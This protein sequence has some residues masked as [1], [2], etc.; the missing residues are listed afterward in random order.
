[1][2]VSAIAWC[3]RRLRRATS[4]EIV[5][6]VTADLPVE[7]LL[8]ATALLA[9][10]L[11]GSIPLAW[12]VVRGAR[13]AA[14]GAL[15]HGTEQDGD[16]GLA[17]DAIAAWGIAGPGWGMLAVVGDLAKGVVPVAVG[18][19]T[20][21]WAAGWAAGLGAVLGACWPAL[22]RWRGGSGIGVLAGV[23]FTL[24]P[25]AGVVSVVL[26]L[27][28]LAV[29]RLLG[30]TGIAAAAGAGFGSFLVLFAAIEQDPVRVASLVAI[31]AI[32]LVRAAATRAR[33]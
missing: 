24:A 22:G 13:T 16:P 27:G 9:G 8:L 25:P 30:R 23:V 29:A 20:W 1:M 33:H 17:T 3:W 28:A 2:S 21:S 19:V 4:R 26:A 15:A 6:P 18:I 5:R 11:A 10:Y 7:A 12:Y 32:P 31:C 14:E